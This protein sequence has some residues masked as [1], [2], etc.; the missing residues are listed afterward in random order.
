[1]RPHRSRPPR[2]RPPRP[3]RTGTATGTATAVPLP[4]AT[5]AEPA[6]A[7][8]GR[9]QQIEDVA[10]TLADGARLVTLT[11]AGGVGKTRL[12]VATAARVRQQY[13]DGAVAV[14][15]ATL[16]DPRLVLPTV[17]HAVGR[18][19]PDPASPAPTCARTS[20]RGSVSAGC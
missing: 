9:E 6:N 11:G 12:A 16:R 1:M 20:P 4:T 13:P 10:A 18:V 17:A 19:V 8:I 3:P 2:R 5:L 15:L 7:L 14:P